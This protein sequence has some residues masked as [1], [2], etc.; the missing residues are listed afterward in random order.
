[1]LQA[2]PRD[3]FQ[4]LDWITS[5]QVHEYLDVAGRPLGEGRTTAIQHVRTEKQSCPYAGSRHYH[6]KPMNVSALRQI[7]PVWD[8][9]ITLLSWLSQRHRARS[10][11]EIKTYDDVLLVTSAGLS[12]PIPWCCDSINPC[13]PVKFPC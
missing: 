2:P 10:Q 8:K 3:A 9:I 13:A 12:L 4:V 7:L 5:R 1:M 6:P 11:S